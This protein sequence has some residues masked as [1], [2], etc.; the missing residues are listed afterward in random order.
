MEGVLSRA[1][2]RSEDREEPGADGVAVA[3]AEK[4]QDTEVG[5]VSGKAAE[6]GAA[7]VPATEGVAVPEKE[8]AVVGAAV[9]EATAAQ[10]VAGR[11]VQAVV[12]AM[13]AA[14]VEQVWA[15]A[16]PAG[17]A[18][19]VA[20]EGSEVT[21]EVQA[22][23]ALAAGASSR[24]LD[25]PTPPCWGTLLWRGWDATPPSTS[26]TSRRWRAQTR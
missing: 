3:G 20:A 5:A 16:A 26:R 10:V 1:G 19:P 15:G 14:E 21:E 17:V 24:N 4:V 6:V 2:V 12:M 9:G 18:A 7:G 22:D 8:A 13:A 23:S 11:A 25:S